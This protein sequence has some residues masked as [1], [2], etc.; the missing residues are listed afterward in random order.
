VLIPGDPV[1]T[2][3]S[4]E[5]IMVVSAAIVTL[6]QLLK[7]FKVIG[8]SHGAPT[9]LLLAVFGVGLWGYSHESFYDRTL[10][11]NYFTAWITVATSAAGVFGFTRA[12]AEAVTSTRSVATN[13][14]SLLR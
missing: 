10:V 2:G 12:A 8:E 5:S 1:S 4:A 3:M 9:V 11:W 7:W 13:L 6:T 14:I